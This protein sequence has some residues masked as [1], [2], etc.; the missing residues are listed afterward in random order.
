MTGLG[1]LSE[2]ARIVSI[3]ATIAASALLSADHWRTQAQTSGLVAAFGF[4]EGTGTSVHDSSSNNIIGSIV[5]ATWTTGRFGGALSF[6]G[7]SS[8]V[9]LGNPAALQ[10]TGSMTLEAWIN[11][12]STPADD[13][14]IIAKSDDAGGWQLKTSPDTGPHTFGI[15]ITP[16]LNS[17]MTQRYS[18]T[19]RAL[20][21]WYHIA[22]VY[23]A[24]AGTLQTYV[25]GALDNGTL[26]GSI[27]AAQINRALNATIGRRSGGYYFGGV[28]DEVRVY[29][30]ALSA[31]EISADMNTPIG[32]GTPPPQD[33]TP[34]SVSISAPA[35][36][37][38]IVGT[39]SVSAAATD[40]VGVAGVQF[41]LD[42]SP[43]GAEALGSPYS[44]QWNTAGATPGVHTLSAIARDLSG[45]LATSA[46]V[47]VNVQNP[48]PDQIGQWSA[49]ASWP[50]VAVHSMLLTNGDVLAWTDYTTNAGAQIWH[51]ATNTF[52]PKTYSTTSLFCAGHAYMPDGRLLIAGGIVGLIDD[53]GPQDATIFDPATSSWSR[54][55]FMAMGRY[56]PT[57][58]ALGDGRILVMGG[59]TTCGT[60]I[61][62]I[63]EIYDPARDTWTQLA[64]TARLAFKYYPHVFNLPDG[65]ILVTSQDDKAIPTRTL[66]LVTQKWTTVDARVLDGHSAAMYEPGKI[67]KAGTAT[68]DNPGHPSAATTYVLDMTQP[69]PAWEATA[70][71]AFPRSYVDLTLLPDGEVLATGGS[72][73]TDPANFATA[74]YEAEIW[75]PATRRWTTLARAQT[76]RLYHSTA[77]LLPDARVL[78]AGGGR[79]NGRSQPDPADQANAEIF[80]PPYLFKGPRP[81]IATAPST[82]AYGGTFDVATP[83]AARI[84]TVVLMAPGAVTHAF[85]ENQR[86]VPLTFEASAGL[87]TVHEPV[88]G[89]LAPPGPYMLF[90]VDSNGVPSMASWV[91]LPGPGEDVEP[92]TAPSNLT[93]LASFG[94]VALSWTA[95][96]D[97][98]RVSGYNIHRATT[99]GF[100]PAATNKVGQTLDTTYTDT[101]FSS[102]GPYYY[103]V[104]AQDAKGNIS[105][106]SNEVSATIPVDDVPPSVSIAGPTGTV[107]GTVSISA[108]ASDN[109]AVAGVQFLLDG[110]ALGAELTGAGPYTLSWNTATVAN[111]SHMLSARARDGA[112]NITT[113]P[114]VAV[115]VANTAPTGLVAAYSFNEGTGTTLTDLSGNNLNGTIVNAAWSSSGKFGGALS[116]NGTSSYVDLG[117]PAAL[118]LT[119]SMTIEAWVKAA[120]TPADDGQIV[121]KSN[122]TG[123]EFKTSPDTGPHTF[124]VGVSGAT[125]SMTQRYSTTARA[126]NTWYHVAGV[127][128]A[129]GRTLGIYVNG[130]LDNGTL[131]NT[132]P[133]SQVNASVNV[134]IGRRTGGFYFNGLIDEVRIYNR[135]LSGVEIQSDM[136]TPLGSR[137]VFSQ[138]LS[139]STISG[140]TVQVRYSAVGD[141]SGVDH[142]HFQ[143]DAAPEVMDIDFDGNYQFTSVAPGSHVLRGYLAR[144][145]H[146]AIPGSDSTVSFTTTVPDTS[147]PTISITQP[148]AGATLGGPV[149]VVATASDDV[150]VAGVQFLL[151]GANLGSEVLGGGPFSAS[152]DT[153]LAG[154][155]PHILSARARDAAGNVSLAPD[156]NVTVFNDTTAPVVTVSA[157]AAGA[158]VNGTVQV[159]AS[160]TDDVAVTGVQFL[161]DGSPLGNEIA[162]TGPYLIGWDTGTTANGVHTLSARAH[163]AAGNA[164]ISSPVSVTVSNVDAV[165]PAVSLTAPSAG[166]TVGADVTVSAATS[167]NVGVVGVQFLLDGASLGSELVGPGPYAISWNTRTAGNGSH[168]LSAR[169]RD[170][171]G[172]T[173]LSVAVS[174]VVFNDVTP[175]SGA[176]SAPAAGATVSGAV[177]VS[178][179]ASDDVG[180][181]GVQFLVDGTNLGAEVT[182][183]GPYSASWNTTASA[184]GQH[185]ISARLRDTAGNSA[186]TPGVTVTV[187]N[188]APS[189]LLAAYSFSEG[190]GTT[191]ADSSGNGLTGTLSGATW[192]TAGRI[193]KAL[194]FN[195]TSNFVNIGNPTQLRGTGSMSWAAW[196]YATGNPPDDGDIISKANGST[197]WQFKTSPDTGPYTFAI[198]VTGTGTGGMT[199]RYSTT[200]RALNT[201]YHVVGVYD[202]ATRS[203]DI[204]V[205]GVLDNGVLRGTIPSAMTSNSLN[206]N[207]GRRTT[208]FYFRGTIDEVKVFNRALTAAE[209]QALYGSQ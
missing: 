145:D 187:A 157:P 121:A 85:D 182:G 69:N 203:L 185:T 137:L 116:F 61:A 19:V 36:G 181:V 83:D 56:Y 48:T 5:G 37:A 133:A 170:G 117:N 129:S 50:I 200:V 104:T 79:Q 195:G 92:P 27:P 168:Q 89:N 18:T 91:R 124:G 21:T 196:V 135:A 105:G 132:V 52:E 109:V 16:V 184:N 7:S 158:T 35:D 126:L 183:P 152:W 53:L 173:T 103:V 1:R 107:Q 174:V 100:T 165:P 46:V 77:L 47:S 71:M 62:D 131:R 111:G 198:A 197:G 68:A 32:G 122:G 143:L 49:V 209:V 42:G 70:P 176:I 82:L 17:P 51:R 194:S 93:A 90:L 38:T 6:N 163:D 206:V 57:A 3:C 65:R 136:N 102:S 95:S 84:A 23:D 9:D 96:T 130:V 201:W 188:T 66:D 98:V 144:A 178:A 108:T 43:L 80:S 97:N 20:N 24:S 149:T 153:R 134:N 159:S 192:T 10:L 11:A 175:P 140:T 30:R 146:S 156:T 172:N 73:T 74:V 166:A 12:R 123:W 22:G 128:D 161:L 67:I 40:D 147:A 26:R 167:D 4:N 208:G 190:T 94:S 179:T 87:L 81:V 155:G 76:P 59:T 139:G 106:P 44:V 33:T 28:I 8:Y 119:G 177:V 15:A 34:P 180:V 193:G 39:V 88:D 55:A 86:R 151:D 150:G 113:A 99:P 72:T 186:T 171:A 154:N 202:A 115:I 29:N 142:A 54:G 45:N 78:V 127:F 120:A 75:S 160:A 114:A 199:Q 13:G 138:P 41:Q 125:G 63:P 191:T 204:Y 162:G 148:L 14:Q 2:S 112:G 205:N 164:S 64:S 169:A 141:L 101:A 189:G 31:A 25:N 58:T 207:I 110:A 60:C 118:Q